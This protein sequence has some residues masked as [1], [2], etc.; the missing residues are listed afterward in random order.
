MEKIFYI[1]KNGKFINSNQIFEEN[2]IPSIFGDFKINEFLNLQKILNNHE[3]E[4]K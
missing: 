1:G 4:I 3:L 2:K